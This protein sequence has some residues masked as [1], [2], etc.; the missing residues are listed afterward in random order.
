MTTT[1]NTPPVPTLRQLGKATGVAALVAAA[2]LTVA[3]LP[4][5]YGIDPTGAGK[6]LGLT[7]MGGAGAAAPAAAE[8]LPTTATGA[9]PIVDKTELAL[10]SDEMTIT[11]KPGEGAEVKASIRKG[12]HF[13]FHWSA[14]APVKSDMH[15]EPHNARPNEFTTYWKAP[16]QSSGSGAFTAPF[17]GI[18]G[19]FWRN[20]NDKPVTITVKVDG[21][22]E[23][24]YRPS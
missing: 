7:K 5:E 2:I 11:L 24:L 6:L 20:K 21:F 13:V 14:D 10:R 22:Q 9:G 23:K 8:V 19:W 4:A 16:Q 17:D 18:H 12:Q 3:V 15:G 1:H